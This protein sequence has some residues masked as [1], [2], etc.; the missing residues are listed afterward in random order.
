M[1]K[2]QHLKRAAAQHRIEILDRAEPPTR[3]FGETLRYPTPT[4]AAQIWLTAEGLRVALP[5]APGELG[6]TILLPIKDASWGAL[7]QI[8]RERSRAHERADRRIGHAAAPTQYDIER[9]LQIMQGR[10]AVTRIEPKRPAEPTT[11]ADLGLNDTD[12]T[13]ETN[14]T[15]APTEPQS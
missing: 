2:R 8:M 14:E 3:T 12:G 11:L 4:Y 6:H 10:G 1:N 5:A 7:L 9:M 15:N 13:N